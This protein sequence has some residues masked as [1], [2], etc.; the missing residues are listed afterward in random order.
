MFLIS[1][2]FPCIIHIPGFERCFSIDGGKSGKAINSDVWLAMWLVYF[3]R[4]CF[5][6]PVWCLCNLVVVWALF[7]GCLGV[8]YLFC[9]GLPDLC[10]VERFLWLLKSVCVRAFCVVVVALPHSQC[11]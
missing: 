7:F 10:F 9:V 1:L 4:L 3:F 8:G 6:V 11:F 2:W 5:K